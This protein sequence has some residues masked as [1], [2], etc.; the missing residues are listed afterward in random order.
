MIVD[1]MA[2]YILN[3]VNVYISWLNEQI[4]E[5]AEARDFL[6][7]PEWA[8]SEDREKE[9]LERLHNFEE[10]RGRI[11]ERDLAAY[12]VAQS[13]YYLKHLWRFAKAHSGRPGKAFLRHQPDELK[14]LGYWA[15]ERLL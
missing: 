3:L 9:L 7:G 11:E 2:L 13:S 14:N 12:D 10:L 8:E 5:E 15:A 1:K 6:D 4:G